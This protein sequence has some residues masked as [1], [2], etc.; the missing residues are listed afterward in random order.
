MLLHGDLHHWNIISSQRQS[1]LALDP[2]GIVGEPIFE[3]GALLRNPVN[4]I[5]FLPDLKDITMRRLEIL[6]EIL[7]FEREHMLKWSLAQAVLAAQWSFEMGSDDWQA[8]E[9]CAGAFYEI[10]LA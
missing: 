5:L 2:K 3:V 10:L 6:T 7:A 9:Y 8:F 1:W 4:K